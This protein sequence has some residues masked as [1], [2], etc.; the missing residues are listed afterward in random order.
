MDS[1]V[2]S[3]RAQFQMQQEIAK[4]HQPTVMHYHYP[5]APSNLPP[6]FGLAPD[7]LVE[8]SPFDESVP[9]L[10]G[11]PSPF[12]ESFPDTLAADWHVYQQAILEM[13]SFA[14]AEAGQAAAID[15]HFALE[16]GQPTTLAS[17]GA[18]PTSES[19]GKVTSNATGPEDGGDNTKEKSPKHALAQKI[20]KI[21]AKFE[22]V[23]HLPKSLMEAI[24]KTNANLVQGL[25]KVQNAKSASTPSSSK[26]KKL[27]TSKPVQQQIE[28]QQAK[29]TKILQLMDNPLLAQYIPASIT[30]PVWLTDPTSETPVEPMKP[31]QAFMK[32]H[33]FESEE[34]NVALTKMVALKKFAKKTWKT[35]EAKKTAAEKK[36]EQLKERN[37]M[38]TGEFFGQDASNTW[39]LCLLYATL[40]IKS[41]SDT[42][43][44]EY[45]SQC[46]SFDASCTRSLD[47]SYIHMYIWTHSN[48]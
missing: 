38:M 47:L 26:G 17:P 37:L 35:A 34:E 15:A 1:G 23:Q 2:E 18:M 41:P 7:L 24:K 20:L 14:Q 40:L 8:S 4:L 11:A 43:S 5:P 44:R 10:V 33:G 42:L 6:S 13:N 36:Q 19:E 21:Q 48:T 3:I 29:L 39:G 22:G 32:L 9:Y 27:T 25:E 45:R 46:L 28:E 12:G 30:N 16:D 31:S